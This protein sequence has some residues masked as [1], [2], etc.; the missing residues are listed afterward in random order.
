MESETDNPSD[1]VSEII[2]L[3]ADTHINFN[4]IFVDEHKIVNRDGV[5]YEHRETVITEKIWN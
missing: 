1:S 2:H 4:K 5:D 3:Y